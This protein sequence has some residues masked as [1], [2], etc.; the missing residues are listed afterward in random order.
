GRGPDVR[1][2]GGG[3][4]HERLRT[5][6]HPPWFRHLE[7]RVVVEKFYK[8]RNSHGPRLAL[9]S[10][11]ICTYLGLAQILRTCARTHIAETTEE[12]KQKMTMRRNIWPIC[13]AA[14]LALG[15]LTAQ[16]IPIT[17]DFSV[18]A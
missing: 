4:C 14:A 15:P 18:T 6:P 3:A 1:T 16:A 9:N 13:A 8:G 7:R 11:F 17:Y 5:V 10:D 12:R 2:T